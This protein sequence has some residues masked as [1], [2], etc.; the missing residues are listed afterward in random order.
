[1][2]SSIFGY[3]PDGQA[4]HK[5]T[6]SSGALEATIITWGAAIQD[7]RL[8]GHAAP[9]VIGYRDFEDYP[10][11]SPHLGA[12]AGRFSNRIRNASFEIDGQIYHV[13]PNL[14]GKHNLHG[15]SKG[16]GHRVWN[17]VGTGRDFVTLA[18]IASD[19]EMGFP[20]NL[21]VHCTYMINESGTLI[22]RLEAVTDKPTVCNLLHHSYFNLDDGGESDI[23]EHQL[24]IEADAYLPVNE[25]LIA[26]GRVLPVK[27]TPYDFR[28]FRKIR[29]EIEGKQ[30]EYDNNYCLS[31]A[32]RPL[33][34]CASVKAARSGVRLDVATTEPG[35][36]FY[37]G[38]SMGADCI[39]LTGKPYANY[40][41]FCLEPQIWPGSLEYPYFP[42]S[43]LR[44][45]EIYAQTSHFTFTKE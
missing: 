25:E 38:N 22:V 37:S 2:K 29:Y 36:Q 11:H 30:L 42:Q 19:G 12:V 4:V 28:S 5:L 27:D 20:G 45:G 14:N 41:G 31:S 23:L 32:R 35:L 6:I 1:M 39:G 9:L 17:V 24:Q 15:G 43:I 16:L 13:E 44:P 18:T 8:K 10:A 7:L 33:R 34:K 40:A 21:N 26:D 3:T